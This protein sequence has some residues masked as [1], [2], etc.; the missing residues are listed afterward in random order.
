[1]YT[2]LQTE[3]FQ[4]WMDDLSDKRAQLHIAARLRLAEAGNLGD[5]VPSVVRCPSFEST[6]AQVTG[7]ISG[8]GNL[9]IIMHAGGDKSSQ[10]RDIERA[11]KIASELET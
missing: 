9:L 1:M 4:T 7:S 6:S 3:E 10:K 8:R 5:W 11:Q 2:V